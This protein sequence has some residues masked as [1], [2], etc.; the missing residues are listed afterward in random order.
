[1]TDEALPP[2]PPWQDQDPELQRLWTARKEDGAYYSL[3]EI[4]KALGRNV[5]SIKI[6]A[7]RLKLPR[8]DASARKPR[9]KATSLPDAPSAPTQQVPPPTSSTEGWVNC[10]S[11]TSRQCMGRFLSPDKARIR[12]CPRCKESDVFEG[13]STLPDTN[14]RLG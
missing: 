6:R 12:I 11:R 5:N 1:M 3:E 13:A 4:A 2:P 8:R 9:I 10:L 14:V 7:C